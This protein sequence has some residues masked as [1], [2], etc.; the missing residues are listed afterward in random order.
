VQEEFLKEYQN[1]YPQKPLT[2][3][4][5]RPDQELTYAPPPGYNAHLNTTKCSGPPS[6]AASRR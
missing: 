1:K 4:G 6:A 3:E 2:A 5:L